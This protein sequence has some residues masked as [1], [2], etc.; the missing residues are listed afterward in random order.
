VFRRIISSLETANAKAAF[1]K[2]GATCPECGAPPGMMPG[3]WDGVLACPECGAKASVFEWAAA[4]SA[5]GGRKGHAERRPDGT[6]IRREE[7]AG[8]VIWNIPAKG[9]SGFLMVFAVLWLAI[10]ALV[11]GGFL[12][13]YLTGGNIEGNMP[14][15]V[16]I[17]FFSIFWAVGLGVFYAGL[18]EKFMCHIVSVAD[19]KV[20]LVKRMFGREKA[21]SIA[22]GKGTSVSQKEFYRQNYKPVY[23]I[24]IRNE[25]GKLRFGSALTEDEKAW[26]VGDIGRSVAGPGR[27][28]DAV[29]D[30][31]ALTIKL[32]RPKEVFSITLPPP[33]KAA[34][35]VSL[36]LPA[37]GIA[38]FC[39]GLFV[40][41]GNEPP[42]EEREGADNW[43]VMI[44]S[45]F[46]NAF[47]AFWLLFS[48]FFAV[49]GIG[50]FFMTLRKL[51]M[52]QRIEGSRS[53]I[54]IRTYN[55][56]FMTD[57]KSFPRD[58]VADIRA[59]ESGH[60]NG[61]PMKRIELIVGDRAER[62]ADWLD[63]GKADAIVAEMREALGVRN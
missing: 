20:T 26:L 33:G 35:I 63:G 52:D 49:V 28:T 56:G 57:E 44:F 34:L 54:S 10:T 37:M 30:D 11:S 8:G 43:F 55:R 1:K 51:G 47:R 32:A 3:K 4:A 62:I 24:E 45:L 17:P 16:L 36:A 53:A 25:S 41:E 29:R 38:F 59:S 61:N 18:R 12:V 42:S 40:M 21:K 14:E 39:I 58:Q 7:S 13:T 19:G 2:G 50:I 27:S 46:E 5:A 22:A 31:T 9:K 6:A 15:W 48:G 60:N 23:G